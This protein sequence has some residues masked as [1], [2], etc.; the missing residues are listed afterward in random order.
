MK[1]LQRAARSSDTPT[2]M[3]ARGTPHQ[4][5]E[6]TGVR[7]PLGWLPWVVCVVWCS[8]S[9][10][11]FRGWWVP[12]TV[13]DADAG[14]TTRQ[15]L[16]LGS[17]IVVAGAVWVCGRGW[18]TARTHWRFGVLALWLALSTVY[19]ESPPTTMKRAV[20]FACGAVAIAGMMS[21]VRDPMRFVARTLAFIPAAAAW[22]SLSWWLLFPASIT[23]NP[24][25]PGLA[26]ISNHP[27][28]LAPALAIGLIMSIS[29]LPTSRTEHLA[30]IVSVTGCAVALGMTGSITSF[31][32][33]AFGVALLLAFMLPTYGRALAGLI[34]IGT[35]VAL[36][37]AGAGA[38]SESMLNSVG[39]DSSLSGRDELWQ[40]VISRI[41]EAPAFGKGW[42]AFW[43]EGRG[44][45]LV[46]TWNP[47]QSHNAYLD[48]LLD[49]GIV[50]GLVCLVTLGPG[51]GLAVRHWRSAPDASGRR[52]A[53]ALLAVAAGLLLVYAMQQSFI[54]K[55]DTFV[56]FSLMLGI[57]ALTAAQES[58][59]RVE[60]ARTRLGE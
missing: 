47:R 31:G 9:L 34:G 2:V 19:S 11:G 5:A 1:M 48:V 18:E 30:R 25:R 41:G 59:G 52:T 14:S 35:L 6:P 42:G 53:A 23:T 7:G 21:L 40:Q 15:V 38:I 12:I 39:R 43:V 33:G 36:L 13:S 55:V 3:D 17:A 51:L 26:G 16:F 56:F 24:A 45:E 22:V 44:R 8:Y 4:P 27:N 20:V 10:N 46:S 32:F 28:T 50:G 60:E 58:R 37:V 57:A 29:L 54:G 49:L